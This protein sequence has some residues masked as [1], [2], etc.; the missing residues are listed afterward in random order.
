M[1]GLSVDVGDQQFYFSGAPTVGLVFPFK[2]HA[3]FFGDAMLEIGS[4]GD[5][6]GLITNNIVPGFDVG[7]SIFPFS[8]SPKYDYHVGND[9]FD[10]RIDITYRG[11]WFGNKYMHAFGLNFNLLYPE[12]YSWF[13]W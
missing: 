3:K 5:L 1:G 10:L 11:T 8:F 9:I 4:F 7:V 13:P 2:E 6:A 12:L